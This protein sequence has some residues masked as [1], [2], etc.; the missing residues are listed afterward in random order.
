M[1]PPPLVRS[2]N[3]GLEDDDACRKRRRL[4]ML[5]AEHLRVAPKCIRLTSSFGAVGLCAL[6]VA[7]WWFGVSTVYHPLLR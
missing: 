3:L 7:R 5:R 1:P 4:P 6:L 2:C